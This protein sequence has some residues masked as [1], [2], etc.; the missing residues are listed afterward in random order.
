MLL[1]SLMM[2]PVKQASHLSLH[3]LQS[4]LSLHNLQ[5]GPGAC[6]A[7]AW[8]YQ[9]RLR[10]GK[11]SA[12]LIAIASK[13]AS[14][15]LP[16]GVHLKSFWPLGAIGLVCT[17]LT[18]TLSNLFLCLVNCFLKSLLVI[19]FTIISYHLEVSFSVRLATQC[20]RHSI[21]FVKLSPLRKDL[22]RKRFGNFWTEKFVLPLGNGSMR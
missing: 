12:S 16:Q 13:P 17:K 19:E 20:P 8:I 10:S 7:L 2:T 6:Q 5:R 3:N 18:R 4:H 11:C 22:A 9:V 1:R 14:V 21:A 15:N